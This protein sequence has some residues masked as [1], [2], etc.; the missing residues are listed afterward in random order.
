M[1]LITR[2]SGKV[3]IKILKGEKFSKIK[4]SD[5]GVGMEVNK[6]TDSMGL[7]IISSLVKDKLKGNLEIRS[8]KDKGTTIE[9]DFKKLNKIYNEVYCKNRKQ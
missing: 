8:K 2:D 5:N 3:E 1:L 6:E 9:F 7:L 4:I